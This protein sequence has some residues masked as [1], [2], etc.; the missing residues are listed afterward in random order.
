MSSQRN[1]VKVTGGSRFLFFENPKITSKS[2]S[3]PILEFKLAPKVKNERFGC[4]TKTRKTRT[5]GIQ[6]SC[7][8]SETQT[9]PYSPD[10]CFDGMNE[11]DKIEILSLQ[12]L[13]YGH[14]LPATKVD[15]ARIIRARERREEGALLPPI[16]DERTALIHKK[17][18]EDQEMKDFKVREEELNEEIDL[19]ME[20][21]KNEIKPMK[22]EYE[23]KLARRL[24]VRS[25]CMRL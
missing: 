22:T 25:S 14:G 5:I 7:R 3:V 13:T 6:T 4:N 15:I 12:N 11:K 1:Q 21:F 16:K 19:K 18:L 2:S 24:E 20:N 8:D 9:D 10:I 23:L 17:F